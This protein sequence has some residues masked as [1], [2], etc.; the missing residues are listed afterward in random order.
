MET[1]DEDLDET[2]AQ[3]RYQ[4]DICQITESN[5]SIARSFEALVVLLADRLPVLGTGHPEIVGSEGEEEG[6][7]ENAEDGQI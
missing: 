3:A 6:D 7:A 1:E 4:A 5:E 2:A